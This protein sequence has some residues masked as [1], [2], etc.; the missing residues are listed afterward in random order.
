[1][2]F[3]VFFLEGCDFKKKKVT[4]FIGYYDSNHTKLKM[5][6]RLE[7]QIETGEWTY[8]N[9]QGNI[10]QKGFFENGYK[11]GK[12]NF[13][14]KDKQYSIDWEP[15]NQISQF[16]FS[17]PK[18]FNEF[19]AEKGIYTAFD[20][21]NSSLFSIE[22]IKTKKYKECESLFEKNYQNFLNEYKVDSAN[23]LLIKEEQL[24]FWFDDF[25]IEHIETKNKLI[26]FM[27]YIIV[28]NNIVVF[29]FTTIPDN[30]EEG[31]FL[32]EDIFYHF[33]FNDKRV[34][35]PFV[36]ILKLNN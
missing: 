20:T 7:N 22:I 5:K 4:N 12:W 25:E 2:F 10:S 32:I 6:G 14:L 26:I 36:E 15:R 11:K 35:S 31:R 23:S 1:M 28:N 21:I 17:L 33:R 27:I 9:E 29:S 18:T 30:R 13:W 3:Y 24:V 34:A 8:Y 16:K 19:R